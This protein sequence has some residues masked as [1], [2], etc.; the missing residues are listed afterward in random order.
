META[1]DPQIEILTRDNTTRQTTMNNSATPVAAWILVNLLMI[2]IVQNPANSILDELVQLS[3]E[4]RMKDK[5]RTRPYSKNVMIFCMTL[6]GYSAKAYQFVRGVFSSCIPSP[7]TLRNYRMRVDG[8][9]GYSR[10]ALN[11]IKR[12]VNEL[13]KSSKKLYL[14]LSCDDISIRQHIWFTGRKFYGHEDLGEGPG[15]K[16][17]TH[18]MMIMATALNMD[19][20]LPIAY[21]LLA[22][23][24]SSDKR[25]ELIRT[26][27]F[28]LNNT[29]AVL[30]N[31]VMD[32][33][34]TNY[35]TFRR[36]GCILSR[37]Y[38]ELNTA[39][40][41]KNI[42]GKN[43]LA[44]FDPPHLSK[45]GKYFKFY[46]TYALFCSYGHF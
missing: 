4:K 43:I 33:C 35:A 2:Y 39:T 5:R 12:K 14:S 7:K 9:P 38:R 25:A 36:L 37:N 23:S 28:H 24:F 20:K 1:D 16:A 30:T 17:A 45:L 31:L 41:M 13:E 11:M 44:M 22:D 42:V 6:A 32:N 46:I 27:I 15:D 8:A 10:A 19:W 40:D 26:C 21:F 3:F 18:V 29:G 34:P